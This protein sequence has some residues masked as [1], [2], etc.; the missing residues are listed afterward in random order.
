M[1]IESFR[2]VWY[3]NVVGFF[4]RL[5]SVLRSYLDDGDDWRDVRGRYS[6]D[7]DIAEAVRELEEFLQG[8]T[9]FGGGKAADRRGMDAAPQRKPPAPE[10]LRPDFAELGL[11]FGAGFEQCKAAYKRLMKV[12][13]PD[14]HASHEGNMKKATAKSAKITTAYGRISKW[15]ETGRV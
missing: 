10:A 2:F 12:H 6:G 15:Y 13:H 9:L 11:E 3:T 5:G 14:R 8:R 7:P 4:D 1:L